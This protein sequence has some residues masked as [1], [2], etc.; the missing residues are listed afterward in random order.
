VSLGHL[1]P[2]KQHAPQFE[3]NRHDAVL[4]PFAGHPEKQILQIEVPAPDAE[5]AG[6][7]PLSPNV[8]GPS[9]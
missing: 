7:E 1:A 8:V 3:R 9:L 5:N 4:P 6:K 2:S